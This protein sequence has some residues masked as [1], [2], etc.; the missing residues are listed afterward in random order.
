MS[1]T[2]KPQPPTLQ[3]ERPYFDTPPPLPH[4]RL[5]FSQLQIEPRRWRRRHLLDPHMAHGLTSRALTTSAKS[6]RA[7]AHAG[8]F[9]PSLPS[10]KSPAGGPLL[11]TRGGLA[12]TGGA[13]LPRW[14]SPGGLDKRRRP[15]HLSP[16]H[17]FSIFHES[18]L[19]LRAIKKNQRRTRVGVGACLRVLRRRRS[20]RGRPR[21]ANVI[22]ACLL[23]W[24]NWERDRQ[25]H[26]N[27]TAMCQTNCF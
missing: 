16:S 14:V 18:F 24:S 3:R 6:F 5:H 27:C 22:S 13:H 19:P 26:K 2:L 8:L 4:R 23:N 21:G 1:P 20:R 25:Q 12:G 7:P 11:I 15:D 9:L 17:A 10:A